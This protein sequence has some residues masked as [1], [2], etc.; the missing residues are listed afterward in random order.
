MTWTAPIHIMGDHLLTS[1]EIIT[2]PDDGNEAVV[3]TLDGIPLIAECDPED[4]FRSH[5][6]DIVPYHGEIHNVLP[7]PVPVSVNITSEYLRDGR[8][9]SSIDDVVVMTDRISGLDVLAFGT[10]Y[11][12]DWYPVFIA[13]WMP[14][15]LHL[16]SD[17]G[18]ISDDALQ[19]IQ[20]GFHGII[21]INGGYIS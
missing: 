6:S 1:A 12:N 16:N 8:F 2:M 7:T 11:C 14:Q 10:L 3:F 18:D 21:T 17:T 15:N 9:R 20:D 5:C 4:G 13:E 19:T